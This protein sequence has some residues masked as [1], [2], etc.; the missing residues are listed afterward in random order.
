[1]LMV[2]H[3]LHIEFPHNL[4]NYNSHKKIQFKLKNSLPFQKYHQEVALVELVSMQGYCSLCYH[5]KVPVKKKAK[6][7][8]TQIY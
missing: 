5:Y 2:N 6:V 7:T 4:P 3:I 1:M 8:V